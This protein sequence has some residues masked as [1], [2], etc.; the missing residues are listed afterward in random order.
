[1][2][3]PIIS[4]VHTN[5]SNAHRSVRCSL[6]GRPAS[7]AAFMRA[8]AAGVKNLGRWTVVRVNRLT[9]A[10]PCSRPSIKRSHSPKGPGVGEVD[11]GPLPVVVGGPGPPAVAA[12]GVR[13][14]RHLVYVCVME[15]PILIDSD[16]SPALVGCGWGI[17]Y[18]DRLLLVLRHASTAVSWPRCSLPLPQ[19]A[20]LGAM[21]IERPGEV[22]LIESCPVHRFQV[23]CRSTLVHRIL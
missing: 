20:A 9:T 5:P 13:E 3:N 12:P 23:K 18:L 11:G 10:K 22:R 19:L 17:A 2:N 16:V 6:W 21:M 8:T 15:G 14:A 4:Y 1:M 7:T